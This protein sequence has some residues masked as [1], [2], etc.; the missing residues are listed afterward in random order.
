M[1][2]ADPNQTGT[3]LRQR[4]YS[5]AFIVGDVEIPEERFVYLVLDIQSG[6]TAVRHGILEALQDLGPEYA[7]YT[8]HNVAVT[9]THSHSGPGA[10]LNYLLPQITSKGFDMQSYEAV[11]SGAILSIRRAHESL[12]PGRLSVGSRRIVNANI[13]RSLWAYLANPESERQRYRDD[14]DKDLTLLRFT[15]S[16][17][18]K[19]IGIFT[20]FPVHGTS[21]LGNNTLI[22]GDNK[23]VAAY[24]FEKSM[25]SVETAAPDFV[26]GFSQ[27]NVG[28][29]SPNVLGAYCEYGEDSG[30]EC[31]LEDSLCGGRNE[32]CHG[33]GPHWG[34]HDGGTKSCFEIGRL[35]FAGAKAIYDDMIQQTRISSIQKESSRANIAVRGRS[36]RSFHNFVD[37]SHYEFP[38]PNGSIVSTCPAALGYSFAAGTTDGPGRFDF[39]QNNSGD[40]DASPMWK[41]VR[42]F[43]H[44]P[45]NVQKA[46]HGPKPVLL[47][48][49]ET[50]KPY[51]WSPNIVD[52][53]I[54]RIGQI[55]IIV[56]PGEASTMAGRRWREA[57]HNAVVE[58]HL[59]SSSHSV[60]D[61]KDRERFAPDQEPIVLLGGPANTY[62]HYI[63]TEEEYAIQRYEG[64]S[65]L[66]GPHTLNAYINLTLSNLHFMG[67]RK[68]D[69]PQPTIFPPI[70]TNRS[71]ALNRPV[72]VDRSGLFSTFGDVVEDVHP[73]YRPGEIVQVRF[74]GANPRNNL[75]LEGTFTAIEWLKTGAP[76][77]MQLEGEDELKPRHYGE[78]EVVRDDSD[79]ELV[80]EWK[81]INSV[82]GTSEVTISWEIPDDVESGEY[83]IRY[84]GDAKA[85][86]GDISAFAGTSGVF[87]IR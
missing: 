82:F 73:L 9:G 61:E 39:K 37:L 60:S 40:P 66:Y 76:E 31:R 42:K 21:M 36:V 35:Q 83:R 49:G 20:W 67:D 44:E 14:V 43:I 26:A 81:R 84:Y 17:D 51:D 1:G 74:V 32:P 52:I 85:L 8:Q 18:G 25:Q 30:K 86:G 6:D 79:W 3:G 13:N 65:T 47:D 16:S 62:T 4:L 56:S 33:R 7:I 71:L 38:H 69:R 2:Y 57:V 72:I 58:T 19:D 27:S 46:C 29:T 48:V 63:T 12:T 68:F 10:W 28:D 23:G 64:A 54:L 15:Q 78:W 75:R 50:K 5:R 24:L 77:Y 70:N 45:S 59:L 41:V 80:Y 87:E 53:Q 22:T 55:I 34:L 11:V